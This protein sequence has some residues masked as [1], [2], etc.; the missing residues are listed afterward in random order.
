M[1]PMSWLRAVV[2]FTTRP[3]ANTP[4]IRFSRTSPVSASTRTSTKCA[5]Y[6]YRGSARLPAH[7]LGGVRLGGHLAGRRPAVA[8]LLAQRLRGA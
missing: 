8:Q 2:G 3:A 4:S 6:A 1:P 5:P 7:L